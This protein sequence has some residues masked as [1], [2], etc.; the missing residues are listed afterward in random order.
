MTTPRARGKLPDSGRPQAFQP[1]SGAKKLVIK[2]L[3]APS[4]ARDKQVEEYYAQTQTEL[5]K[6]LEAVFSAKRL[7]VPFERLYRGV[8]DVCRRGDADKVYRSLKLAMETHVQDV[9]QPRVQ[10][11]GGRSNYET[12]K[13]LLSEWQTFNSQMVTK[14]VSYP[15]SHT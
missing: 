3:R 7:D 12:L 8:E 13:C 2:N 15:L 5:E 9:I 1:F 11:N 6:A 10:Q 4:A 14:L